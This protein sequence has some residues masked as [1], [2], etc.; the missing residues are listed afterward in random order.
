MPQQRKSGVYVPPEPTPINAT[1]QRVITPVSTQ[2]TQTTILLPPTFT[3]QTGAVSQGGGRVVNAGE[4]SWYYVKTPSGR[5]ERMKVSQK[6]VD[7]QTPRGWKFSLTD[8][9]KETPTSGC[10]ECESCDPMKIALG[11]CDCGVHCGVRPPDPTPPPPEKCPTCADGYTQ[12]GVWGSILD[13]CRCV[14][15]ED[16]PCTKQCTTCDSDKCTECDAWDVPC[17]NCRKK[18]GTCTDPTPP[19]DIDDCGCTFLDFGCKMGCYWKKYGIYVM[20]IGG[21]IG[22]GIVLWLLRPLFSVIGAFKGGSP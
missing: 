15:D 22:L 7:V 16:D 11:T 2:Q 20:V 6:F 12:L 13:P 21:L 17:E 9:C 10:S 4:T 3:P 14:K 18:N 19:D 1:E 5:C 8:I